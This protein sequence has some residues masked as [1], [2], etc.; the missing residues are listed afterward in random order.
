MSQQQILRGR[1]HL[2]KKS[3]PGKSQGS[4]GGN[5]LTSPTEFSLLIQGGRPPF[6]DSLALE[7]AGPGFALAFSWVFTVFVTI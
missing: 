7:S 5:L 3:L 4:S 1:G 6:G 2:G